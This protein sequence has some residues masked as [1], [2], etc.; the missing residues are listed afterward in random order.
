MDVEFDQTIM[1]P[2]H[3]SNPNPYQSQCYLR[4]C[5]H[6]HAHFHHHSLHPLNL[7]HQ[8]PHS[9]LAPHPHTDHE[10]P[11]PHHHPEPHLHPI[12][13]HQHQHAPDPH[14]HNHFQLH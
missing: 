11:A 6:S 13:H 14:L 1:D 7:H 2:T 4:M 3:W 5:N 10:P 8:R 9:N 12:P